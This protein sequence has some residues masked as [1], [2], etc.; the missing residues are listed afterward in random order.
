M[1]F[2]CFYSDDGSQELGPKRMDLSNLVV[3]WFK[4]NGCV[5][6][7]EIVNTKFEL[8]MTLLFVVFIFRFN[9]NVIINNVSR[10]KL[11]TKI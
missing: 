5:S 3:S 1:F 8:N 7:S 2:G 4:E 6:D 11:Q 10:R 9:V